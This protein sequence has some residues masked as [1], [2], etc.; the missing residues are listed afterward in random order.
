MPAP[1]RTPLTPAGLFMEQDASLCQGKQSQALA[2]S[3]EECSHRTGGKFR[4]EEPTGLCNPGPLLACATGRLHQA[5]HGF[6][7]PEVGL[8]SLGEALSRLSTHKHL[9]PPQVLSETKCE[10]SG[11]CHRISGPLLPGWAEITTLRARIQAC[12]CCTT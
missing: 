10:T 5:A 3:S 2:C 7:Q 1:G 11:C 4:V 9:C 6:T 12:C 8:C